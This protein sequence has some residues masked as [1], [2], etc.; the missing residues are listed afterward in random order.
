MAII[1]YDIN[2]GIKYA[3]VC[4]SQ[5]VDGKVKSIQKSLGRVLDEY[6][7]ILQNRESGVFTCDVKTGKYGVPDPSFVPKVQRANRRKKLILDFSDAYF[8]DAF[9]Q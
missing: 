9:M 7:C 4:T 8:V 6:K 5:R 2:N 1:A 3:K